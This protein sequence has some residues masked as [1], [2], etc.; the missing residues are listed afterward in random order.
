[1]TIKQF[2]DLF[3]YLECVD[4]QLQFDRDGLND[5]SLIE[6]VELVWKDG[7][8]SQVVLS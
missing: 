8:I 5:V 7:K 6:R 1:M 3:Q 2:I 4:L